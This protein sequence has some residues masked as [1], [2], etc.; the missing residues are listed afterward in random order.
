MEI[1]GDT[2]LVAMQRPKYVISPREHSDALSHDKGTPTRGEG[3]DG[4]DGDNDCDGES[5]R[6]TTATAMA[7]TKTA[8]APTTMTTI[9][10]TAFRWCWQSELVAMLKRNDAIPG[11][12]KKTAAGWHLALGD[13]S[14][15]PPLV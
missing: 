6:K 13:G 1:G 9:I 7:A 11:S 15:C 10:W 8:A 14:P 5:T 2:N 3:D 12:A 4:S